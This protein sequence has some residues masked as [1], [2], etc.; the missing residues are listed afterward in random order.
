MN[1]PVCHNNNPPGNVYCGMCGNQI[2]GVKEGL[3]TIVSPLLE[4]RQVSILFS[5]LSGYTSLT[6]A[7]DPEVLHVLVY[8]YEEAVERIVKLYNGHIAKYLGDGI[9]V[10]YGY[11]KAHEDDAERCV[12]SGIEIVEAVNRIKERFGIRIGSLKELTLKAHVGI[13]TGQLLV[14]EIDRSDRR[15]QIAIG[16]TIN[17]A[18]RVCASAGPDEVL[19]TDET[20][21]VVGGVF[22]CTHLGE[23][24]LKGITNP[25]TLFRILGADEQLSRYGARSRVWSTPFT[26]R[27][28]ET[29]TIREVLN[30]NRI[31]ALFLKGE[32]GIGKSRLVVEALSDAGGYRTLQCIPYYRSYAYFPVLEF[33]RT[34]LELSSDTPVQDNIERLSAGMESL[35]MDVDGDL[36]LLAFLLNLSTPE[37]YPPLDL[38]PVKF[39][40]RA[41]EILS[42][43]LFG[44]AKRDNSIHV[45]EDLHWSDPSTIELIGHILDINSWH[46]CIVG[47]YRPEFEN[48]W[49][50]KVHTKELVLERLSDT[51]AKSMAEGV[52][53][54]KDVAGCALSELLHR[55]HGVPLF[56]EELTKYAL[57]AGQSGENKRAVKDPGD[58]PITLND[59]LMARVDS[60]AEWKE[61]VHVG[62]VVGRTFRKEHIAEVLGASNEALDQELNRLRDGD[63]IY[64]HSSD[65]G[66]E[67][68]FK[69]ALI[70]EAVYG[71]ILNRLKVKY[72]R[73]FADMMAEEASSDPVLLAHH[74]SEANEYKK[75]VEYRLEAGRTAAQRSALREA[76]EHFEQGLELIDALA[77]S[78]ERDGVELD[79]LLGFVEP[80]IYT[81]GWSSERL[82]GVYTRARELCIKLKNPE[83]EI[84]VL[85]GYWSYLQIR[86]EQNEAARIAERMLKAAKRL[87]TDVQLFEARTA[88]LVNDYYRGEHLASKRQFYD[89][90]EVFNNLIKTGYTNLNMIALYLTTGGVAN[91]FALGELKELAKYRNIF[92]DIAKRLENKFMIG[93]A[94]LSFSASNVAL[95]YKAESLAYLE[96][97]LRLSYEEGYP[98]FISNALILRGWVTRDDDPDK[99]LQDIET[100]LEQ[101]KMSGSVLDMPRYLGMYSDVLAA[102]NKLDEALDTINTALNLVD[103][104][105]DRCMETDIIRQKAELLYKIDPNN[106]EESIR[107]LKLSVETGEKK[108]QQILKL[109]ALATLCQMCVENK[110]AVE[111]Y[112]IKL[113][114][115]YNLLKTDTDFPDL[116]RARKILKAFGEKID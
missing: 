45:F 3:Q 36:P 108:S 111:D 8:E 104:N 69:H 27:S 19:I 31:K 48:P 29:E 25:V 13:H 55:A 96:N 88:C 35:G 91:M 83:K 86:A 61:V 9:L 47:T 18:Y 17:I 82:E 73:E 77:E 41:I 16:E 64:E 4:H 101:Y 97:V 62:S 76:V 74:Y 28:H 102:N 32:A 107:L 79:L 53:G 105:N 93:F 30:G 66:A 115:T 40:E 34:E 78:E 109:R 26:N 21:G 71:S 92:L 60:V 14:G 65:E 6:E 43:F 85:S 110:L 7:I 5:D 23:R 89:A 75:A 84:T 50:D 20:H 49:L 1:C 56:I 80:V 72:H 103:A 106:L 98:H 11:P 59:F 12:R 90:K 58:L 113:R 114:E 15:E 70:H 81:E 57:E 42:S 112:K 44:A 94:Q 87:G 67:Y 63:I 116:I 99:A 24:S 51:D 54:D 100:G 46:R 68:E 10:Y 39:K 95:R 38:S 37:V 33:I 52:A 2:S 22:S